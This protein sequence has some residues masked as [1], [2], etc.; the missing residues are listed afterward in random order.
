[1]E[2]QMVDGALIEVGQRRQFIGD[3]EVAAEDEWRS[4]VDEQE[5]TDGELVEEGEPTD[6]HLPERVRRVTCGRWAMVQARLRSRQRKC[7]QLTDLLPFCLFWLDVV[8]KEGR[9]SG[10]HWPTAV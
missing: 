9:A 5:G 10:S 6:R 8:W 2:D 7:S 4:A 1:M 3:G